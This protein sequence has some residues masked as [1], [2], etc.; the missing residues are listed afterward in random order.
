MLEPTTYRFTAHT[1]GDSI[2]ITFTLPGGHTWYEIMAKAADLCTACGFY[3]DG[4]ATV[5]EIIDG[6]LNGSN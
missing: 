1:A 4:S 3:V 5:E 6:A 2:E